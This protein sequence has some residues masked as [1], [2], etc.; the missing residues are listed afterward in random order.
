MVLAAVERAGYQPG[1]DCFLALDAAAVLLGTDLTPD[2]PHVKV[3]RKRIETYGGRLSAV[4]SVSA[5]PGTL[6]MLGN[7]PGATPLLEGRSVPEREQGYLIHTTRSSGSDSPR[8][9]C[10]QGRSP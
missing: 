7:S 5:A 2:G 3:L 8:S 9:T 10:H 1:S 6:I 4:R